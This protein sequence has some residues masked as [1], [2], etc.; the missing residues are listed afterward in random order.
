MYAGR[1]TEEGSIGICRADL[2]FMTT[3]QDVSPERGDLVQQFCDVNSTEVEIVWYKDG[4]L[5][6]P[7]ISSIMSL[8]CS[9]FEQAI[10]YF[11][12]STLASSQTREEFKV[13]LLA[14]ECVATCD[15]SLCRFYCKQ[16]KHV[17]Y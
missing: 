15:I 14:Y 8:L 4:K 5:L 9:Q 2:E 1:A 10:K 17:I 3:P 12:K 7:G 16:F 13:L 11:T 6:A